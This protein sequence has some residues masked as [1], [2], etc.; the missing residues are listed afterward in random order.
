MRDMKYQRGQPVIVNSPEDG[1]LCEEGVFVEYDPQLIDGERYVIVR[2]I[3]DMGGQ[4]A[5]PESCIS[6]A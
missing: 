5:V 2:L 1:I 3:A 6:P 4:E